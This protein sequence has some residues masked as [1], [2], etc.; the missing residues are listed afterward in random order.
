MKGGVHWSCAWLAVRVIEARKDVLK[1][2]L[3]TESDSSALSM[4]H[5]DAD[6]VLQ[7]S[8]ITELVEASNLGLDPI[9]HWAI[10]GGE[11]EIVHIHRNYQLDIVLC[12]DIDT[13]LAGAMS[14]AKACEGFMQFL[15]PLMRTLL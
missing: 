8:Q 6:N 13:A 9:K 7:G 3:L 15:V 12:K 11:G 10:I 4:S 14:E 2:L 5:F 1:I